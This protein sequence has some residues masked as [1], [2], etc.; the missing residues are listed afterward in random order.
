V[1]S[2]G[3]FAIG[4]E[5]LASISREHDTSSLQEYGGV[6]LPRIPFS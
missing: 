6:C 4:P 5:Q 2:T 1:T 3:E